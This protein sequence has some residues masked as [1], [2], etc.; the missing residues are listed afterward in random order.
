[1]VA[2]DFR[3]ERPVAHVRQENSRD[4]VLIVLTANPQRD[5]WDLFSS[6]Q[7]HLGEGNYA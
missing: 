4:M 6:L 7:T 5:R 3:A 2:V 1:M